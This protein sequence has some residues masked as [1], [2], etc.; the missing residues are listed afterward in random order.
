MHLQ[1]HLSSKNATPE[2][3]SQWQFYGAICELTLGRPEQA[4]SFLVEVLQT[5]TSPYLEEARWY[6]AMS[7]LKRDEVAVAKSI[8]ARIAREGTSR[9]GEAGEVLREMK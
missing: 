7:Q 9:K 6:L 8:L 5:P 3:L 2:Q 4:V 1:T